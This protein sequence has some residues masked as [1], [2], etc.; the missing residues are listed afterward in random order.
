MFQGDHLSLTRTLNRAVAT[1]RELN[2]VRVGSEHLLL[3]LTTATPAATTVQPGMTVTAASSGPTALVAEHDR[4]DVSAILARHGVTTA[5][6]RE[7]RPWVSEGGA[8]PG[9]SRSSR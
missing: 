5:A 2:H 4:A 3:A 9:R 1:A 8:G 6:V 7:R